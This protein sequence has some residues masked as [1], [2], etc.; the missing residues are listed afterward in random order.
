MIIDAHNHPDW[1]GKDYDQVIDC[2]YRVH[3]VW[4]EHADIG[5][6]YDDK[7]HR[8]DPGERGLPEILPEASE[9]VACK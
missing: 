6:E 4:P 5:R 1:W 8:D 9:E 3:A 7:D 2:R